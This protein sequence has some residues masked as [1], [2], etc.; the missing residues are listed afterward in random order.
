[1]K[2]LFDENLSPAI[3]RAMRE[4]RAGVDEVD[5]MRNKFGPG[6][7]DLKWISQLSS[8][9]GWI[10]VSGDRRITANKAERMAFKS[11]TLVGFFMAKGLYK[12]PVMRQAE[13]LI[14]LWDSIEKQTTLAA[15][16]SMFELAVSSPKLKPL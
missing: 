7:T 2:V 12:S 11:S 8:E 5:W 4:L 15:P 1:M 3:A 10:V 16:G 6:V 13:R 9:R 14:R